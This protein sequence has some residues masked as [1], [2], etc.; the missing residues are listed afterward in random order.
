MTNTSYIFNLRVYQVA[1]LAKERN[2][3]NHTHFE[4][5]RSTGRV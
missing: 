5:S 2:S 1:F 4:I 3:E